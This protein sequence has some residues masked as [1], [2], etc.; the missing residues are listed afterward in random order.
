MKIELWAILLYWY[1]PYLLFAGWY[2][3]RL[4]RR[5]KRRVPTHGMVKTDP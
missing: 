5:P 3:L 2:F 4:F 1:L